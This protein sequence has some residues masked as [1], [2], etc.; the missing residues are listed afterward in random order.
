LPLE[1]RGR[2]T[3]QG[4]VVYVILEAAEGFRARVK[5]WQQVY[6]PGH[7]APIPFYIV[8]ATL[9]LIKDHAALVAAIR[10]QLDGVAPV[11]VTIDTL[12]RALRGSESSDE[13]MTAFVRAADYIRDAFDCL[14]PIVHHCGHAGGRPRGHSSL[15]GAYDALIR[16]ERPHRDVIVA[17]VQEMKDGAE[18]AKITCGT[19]VETV[20]RDIDDKP[21]TG[22]VAI[23]SDGLPLDGQEKHLID[24]A[25]EIQ[26]K[27]A[28]AFGDAPIS[29]KAWDAEALATWPPA[30]GKKPAAK[31][32]ERVRS[33]LKRKKRAKMADGKKAWIVL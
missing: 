4:A 21:I 8:A 6:C 22:I 12:A 3:E 16:I 19:T 2:R 26:R 18:G 28:D 31:S 24:A 33:E 29:V 14:T 7:K 5:A 30:L 10:E 32:L 9:D 1:Y 13:D 15:L 20:G 27:A 25:H 11:A 23:A 17:E